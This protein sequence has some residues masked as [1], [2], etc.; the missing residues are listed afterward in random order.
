METLL[1]GRA[2]IF[3]MYCAYDNN[4]IKAHKNNV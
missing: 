2:S 4:P 1:P 3:L